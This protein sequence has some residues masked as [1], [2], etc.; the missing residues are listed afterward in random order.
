VGYTQA[1]SFIVG[2]PFLLVRY[3]IVYRRADCR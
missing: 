1:E 3:A 2:L